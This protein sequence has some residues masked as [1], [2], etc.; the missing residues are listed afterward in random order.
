MWER[1][2]FGL[3]PLCP[4]DLPITFAFTIAQPIIFVLLIAQPITFIQSIT[5]IKKV[6]AIMS[7]KQ[8]GIGY[9]EKLLGCEVMVGA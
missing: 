2:P 8:V 7:G 9:L 6:T 1:G 4:H 5:F 3:I